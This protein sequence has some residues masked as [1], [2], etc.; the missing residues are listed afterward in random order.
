MKTLLILSLA[1]GLYSCGNSKESQD[2]NNTTQE[3]AQSFV[4]GTVI[5][6]TS[7]EGCDFII[8]IQIDGNEIKLEPG[9]LADEFK[10]D[11]K[12]VQLIYTPSRRMSSCMGTQPI[13]IEKIK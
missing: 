2:Q 12:S 8:A 10:V 13:T 1:L 11:G 3:V 6:M 5:D 9:A 7:K 4:S